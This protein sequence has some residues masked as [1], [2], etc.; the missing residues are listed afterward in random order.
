MIFVLFFNV[1]CSNFCIGEKIPEYD[2]GYYGE[3]YEL[4]Y[5]KV[6]FEYVGKV[7]C[8]DNIENQ[9]FSILRDME[10]LEWYNTNELIE[11][12]S[13]S[14]KNNRIFIISYNYP[15]EKIIY[16]PESEVTAFKPKPFKSHKVRVCKPIKNETVDKENAIYFYQLNTPYLVMVDTLEKD[17]WY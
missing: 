14:F 7:Q 10:E 11:P 12:I 5:E 13:L 4:N 15:I 9:T 8:V 16:Y 6:G 3:A 2:D 1:S 17:W